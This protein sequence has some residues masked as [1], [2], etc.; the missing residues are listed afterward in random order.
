[1]DDFRAR[2]E[3]RNIEVRDGKMPK[4]ASRGASHRHLLKSTAEKNPHH[5]IQSITDF[6][7]RMEMFWQNTLGDLDE[8]PKDLGGTDSLRKV[9]DEVIVALIDDGVDLFNVRQSKNVLVGRSFDFQGGEWF[10][11]AK[12]HGTAMA[13]RI[14]QV[15]PMAKIY[16]IRLKT[17]P[18]PGGAVTIDG[19]YIARVRGFLFPIGHPT[20][21][22]IIADAIL[23]AILTALEQHA[24]VISI[25]WSVPLEDEKVRKEGKPGNPCDEQGATADSYGHWAQKSKRQ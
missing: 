6:S 20:A 22:R 19:R 21:L 8:M 23:Q 15:C 13:D 24:T 11:S 16:P 17:Y 14:L 18:T 2:L 9:R 7:E 4:T 5:W 3:R 25:S 12:N 1:M 10:S